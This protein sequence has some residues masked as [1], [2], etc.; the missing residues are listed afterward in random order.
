M[1][2][3]LTPQE[4]AYLDRFCYEV[5]HFLHGEGSIF[6]ECPGHYQDLGA[7]TNFATPEVKERWERRDREPP[8][9]VPFPW[10]SLDHLHRRAQ[11]LTLAEAVA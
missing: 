11:E 9:K 3:R 6:Q 10:G 8:P 4:E 1:D 2:L 5:D 7:L